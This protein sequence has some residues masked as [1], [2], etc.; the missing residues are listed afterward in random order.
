MGKGLI[1]FYFY[2]I[3]LFGVF[4]DEAKIFEKFSKT[5]KNT[6]KTK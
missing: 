6:R 3:V 5:A 4:F 1:F 2:R